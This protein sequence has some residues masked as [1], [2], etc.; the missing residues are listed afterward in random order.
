MARSRNIIQEALHDEPTEAVSAEAVG[1]A[2]DPEP[3]G[4]A[5][6]LIDALERIAGFQWASM[7]ANSPAAVAAR[8]MQKIAKDALAAR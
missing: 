2:A 3:A 8:Q 7:D 6:V 5:A 1:H 4:A